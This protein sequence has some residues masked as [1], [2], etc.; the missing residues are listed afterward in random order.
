M[1]PVRPQE[2]KKKKKKKKKKKDTNELNRHTDFEKKPLVTKGDR[3]GG[4]TGVWDWHMHTVVYGMTDQQG[5][6]V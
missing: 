4:W 3:L 1:L 5:P 2:S 6:V